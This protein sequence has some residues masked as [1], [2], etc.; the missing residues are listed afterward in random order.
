MGHL[1]NEKRAWCKMC[2]DGEVE[3][4]R[5]H[6]CQCPNVLYGQVRK[7]WY[8]KMKEKLRRIS[9]KLLE[10]FTDTVVRMILPKIT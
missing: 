9:M 3:D 2:A 4:A 6:M 5:H 1:K 7:A 8:L 10:V